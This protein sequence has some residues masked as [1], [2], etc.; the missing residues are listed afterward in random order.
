MGLSEKRTQIYFPLDLYRRIEERAQRESRSSA[1]LIREAVGRYLAE[2]DREAIDWAGDPVFGL[3]GIADSGLGDL[4]KKHD[5]YL[6]KRPRKN[7]PR[8][9]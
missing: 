8:L 1:A 5:R 6:A 3:A 4:S 2:T 9:F 7:E